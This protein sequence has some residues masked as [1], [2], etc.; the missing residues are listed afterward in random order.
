ME[1][2]DRDG[3]GGVEPQGSAPQQ[4]PKHDYPK[5]DFE[6][7]PAW[8]T[9]DHDT[10]Q[11]FMKRLLPATKR[12]QSLVKDSKKKLENAHIVHAGG[13]MTDSELD[14]YKQ[15]ARVSV[16]NH[17][18]AVMGEL[19]PADHVGT[20]LT[21]DFHQKPIEVAIDDELKALDSQ[22]CYLTWRCQSDDA[23]QKHNAS[24]R[25]SSAQKR[26]MMSVDQLAAFREQK[27]VYDQ[28]RALSRK[29]HPAADGVGMLLQAAERERQAMIAA[30]EARA[31]VE[32]EARDAHAK[33]QAAE[34][35]AQAAEARALEAEARA[36]E[37][38]AKAQAAENGFFIANQEARRMTRSQSRNVT[39]DPQAR[40][41]SAKAYAHAAMQ[42]P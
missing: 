21:K 1:I 26:A 14:G 15:A 20:S 17:H 10:K 13:T 33:A 30:A 34:A 9:W 42:Q 24:A 23:H 31:D 28:Q 32:G 35:R 19:L 36:L 2:D 4:L 25:R 22:N 18:K 41:R 8:R 11:E 29:G 16:A 12:L 27:R 37:A 38:E 3:L 6:P 40:R 5:R 7:H 39:D